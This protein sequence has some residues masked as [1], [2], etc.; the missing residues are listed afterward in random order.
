MRPHPRDINKNFYQNLKKKKIR[1]TNFFLF[2]DSNN[3]L[4][5][6]N[7]SFLMITDLS[8]TAY[9]YAFLTKKPVIFFF[10]EEKI[11]S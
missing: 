8:G 5:T 7:N 9:T 4:E 2:D 11:L 6:Y 1:I 10:Q 3:Y